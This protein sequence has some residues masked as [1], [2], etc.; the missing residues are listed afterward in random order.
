MAVRCR[1]TARAVVVPLETSSHVVR[2]A[3]VVMRGISVATQDVHKPLFYAMHGDGKANIGP[4]GFSS[5]FRGWRRRV[6]GFRNIDTQVSVQKARGWSDF[7]CQT[8]A[9][10]SGLEG[11]RPSEPA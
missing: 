10:E 9:L 1:V 7:A 5:I 11:L 8:L 2:D 3:N 6:R 4:M